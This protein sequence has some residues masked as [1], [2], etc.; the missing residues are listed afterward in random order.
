MYD[1]EEGRQIIYSTTFVSHPDYDVE[2]I[3]NDVSLV[4]LPA[5]K[6]TSYTDHIKPAC[7]PPRGYQEDDLAGSLWAVGWGKTANGANISPVL[8]QLEVQIVSNEE[9]RSSY[10]DIIKPT[11]LCAQGNTISDS[12]MP[13]VTRVL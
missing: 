2:S 5:G 1:P 6:L 12:V 4:R 8:N 3:A 7:L 9:C 11:N 10:G 13:R